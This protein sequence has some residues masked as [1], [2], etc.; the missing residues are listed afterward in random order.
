MRVRLKLET[1]VRNV[2]APG[3]VVDLSYNTRN[4]PVSGQKI[5]VWVVV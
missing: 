5:E 2:K 3:T 4:E 1:V